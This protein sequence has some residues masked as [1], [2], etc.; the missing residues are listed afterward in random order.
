MIN[1][2]EHLQT[3]LHS[4]SL[5]NSLQGS[6]SKVLSE[7]EMQIDILLNQMF[8][9][10]STISLDFW[11]RMLQINNFSDDLEERRSVILRKIR[12]RR[13]TT[14]EALKDYIKLYL[15][16]EVDIEKY[17]H[18]YYVIINITE[19]NSGLNI[20]Q[21]NNVIK[22][23]I[24]AHIN[25]HINA[26]SKLNDVMIHTS[27]T[28]NETKRYTLFIDEEYVYNFN[29]NKYQGISTIIEIEYSV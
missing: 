24:P 5:V 23:V 8:I 3:S 10:T 15:K 1:L 18:E 17:Y 7:Y 28:V 21:I 13:T 25:F 26:F 29:L 27:F 19:Y 9:E 14:I 22:E 2:L 16:C 12:S 20:F 6:Y 11:E 4:D